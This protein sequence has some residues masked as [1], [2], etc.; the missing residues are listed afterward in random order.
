MGGFGEH[1]LAWR[2]YRE[3]TQAEL[4]RRT[5]LP[6]PNLSN[7]ECGRLEPTLSTIRRLSTALEIPPGH[8]ID[9]LPP[10]LSLDRHE[11]DAIARQAI[12]AGAPQ[13]AKHP[14]ARQLGRVI[15]N[16]VAAVTGRPPSRIRSGQKVTTKLRAR[17]GKETW[18]ALVRR[19]DKHLAQGDIQ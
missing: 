17:L 4:A 16:Q 13:R 15:Q 11:L 19:V 3:L 9:E 12:Q 5:D 2:L 18:A 10:P 14:T 6:R 8:L 7:L 1:L